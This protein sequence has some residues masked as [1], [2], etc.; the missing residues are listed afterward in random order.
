MERNGAQKEAELDMLQV[1]NA[2][3]QAQA[4]VRDAHPQKRRVERAAVEPVVSQPSSAHHRPAPPSPQMAVE[5]EEATKEVAARHQAALEEARERIG[6]LEDRIRSA[7]AA[8]ASTDDESQP[9]SGAKTPDAPRDDDDDD[10]EKIIELQRKLQVAAAAVK[11]LRGERIRA[12]GEARGGGDREPP[13]E[14]PS[15]T[16]SSSLPGEESHAAVDGD[17]AAR[18]ESLE[19]ELRTARDALAASEEALTST[20]ERLRAAEESSEAS[21]SLDAALAAAREESSE[22]RRRTTPPIRRHQ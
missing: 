11:R 14:A 4:K 3:L 19:A 5:R 15:T 12:R 18:M 17:A 1:A 7:E 13:P 20:R 16:S 6:D 8:P 10:G 2:A 9:P 22:P 21:S